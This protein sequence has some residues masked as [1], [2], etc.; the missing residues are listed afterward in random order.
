MFQTHLGEIISLGTAICWTATA[1]A[2]QQATRKAGSI[3]VNIIRLIIAFL[4]T[5]VLPTSSVAGFSQ[6]MLH[7]LHGF[8]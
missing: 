5:Q 7:S 2:F 1:L 6:P 4:F 8:G 3:S